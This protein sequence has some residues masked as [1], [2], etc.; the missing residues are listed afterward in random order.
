MRANH[1]AQEELNKSAN[2]ELF[3]TY[4]NGNS[5]W[6]NLVPPPWGSCERIKVSTAPGTQESSMNSGIFPPPD[7]S[8]CL[9]LLAWQKLPLAILC[10]QAASSIGIWPWNPETSGLRGGSQVPSFAL[11]TAHQWSDLYFWPVPQNCCLPST[12]ENCFCHILQ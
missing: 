9:V 1:T 5:I 8:H 2:T 12:E 3:L 11:V 4:K 6:F 10:S 7:S